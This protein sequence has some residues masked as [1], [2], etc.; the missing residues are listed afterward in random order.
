MPLFNCDRVRLFASFVLA[1]LLS[2][3]RLAAQAEPTTP[4][5]QIPVS[6]AVETEGPQN[7]W[8]QLG[9]DLSAE[10]IS[11]LEGLIKARLRKDT[12]VRLVA[13]NDPEAHMHVAVVGAKLARPGGSYWYAVSSVVE[14]A[15]VKGE[16]LLATH[17]LIMAT[18]LD[19]LATDVAYQF[20]SIKLRLML[21]TFK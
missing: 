5:K 1:L 7:V 9:K 20:A 12:T 17:D 3:V 16:D 2:S 21:G 11:E 4:A 19:Q 8:M 10:E 18:N 14:M 15:T 6:V 13:V